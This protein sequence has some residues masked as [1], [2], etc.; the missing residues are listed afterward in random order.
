MSIDVN[1]GKPYLELP[2]HVDQAAMSAD[3]LRYDRV[4]MTLV[5]AHALA[6]LYHHYI[7]HD[8]VMRR[9][10]PWTRRPNGRI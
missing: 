1:R 4:A 7:E 2:G 6:A 9:M 8:D 5:A 3:A 10:L